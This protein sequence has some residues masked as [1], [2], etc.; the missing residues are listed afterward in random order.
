MDGASECPLDP[1]VIL[2]CI[3]AMS[4]SLELGTI[5]SNVSLQHPIFLL[6]HFAQLATL[7]GPDRI[8][9]GLGGG[10]NAEEFQAIGLEM[11]S[12]AERLQRL[13][14]SVIFAR[15]SYLTTE[16]HRLRAG[17]F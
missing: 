3:G 2:S 5:V 1:F 8:I 7:Y 16:S 6:R 4:S 12:H 17:R 9:A 15:D 14:Q 13:R 11:P 10:W